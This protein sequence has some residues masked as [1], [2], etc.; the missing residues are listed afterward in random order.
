M[1]ADNV[2]FYS[3]PVSSGIVTNREFA[4]MVQNAFATRRGLMDKF[5]DPRKDIDAECGYPRSGE[6]T[7][8]YSASAQGYRELY[9][10]MPIARRVVELMPK[11]SWQTTPKVYE[12]NDPDDNTEFEKDW[13]NL[14][15]TLRGEKSWYKDEAGSPVWEYLKRVDILAGIGHFG[16][17]LLGIDDGKNLDQPLDGVVES[18]P[19]PSNPTQNKAK[20]PSTPVINS[21]LPSDVKDEEQKLLPP[22]KVEQTGTTDQQPGSGYDGMSVGGFA[23]QPQG[24]EAQYVGVQ[25]SPSQKPAETPSKQKRQLLFLRAF[26]ESLVQIVQYEADIRN[27]RFGKPVMYRITLN[28]PR[29]QT[30]GIGL[31]TA[32]VRVHW[33]RVIHV[34][35][36]LQSSEVMGTPR[37]EPVLNN[38]LD[39]KKIYGSDAEGYWKSCFGGLQFSTHP[40]LGGDVGV[41]LDQ[42]RDS[43][44]N[45]QQSL[46]RVLIGVGGQWSTIAPSIVDP[47]PHIEVG[48]T[49][50]CIYLS[51]PK[52]IF[53]GS[54]QGQ[55]AADQDSSSWYTKRVPD[56]WKTFNTPRIIIPFVDR[57]IQCGV[58]SEP[59]VDQSKQVDD[60]DEATSKDYPK[61]P[62]DEG[63]PTSEAAPDPSGQ[64]TTSKP[65]AFPT[66]N[67]LRNLKP[68]IYTRQKTYKVQVYNADTGKMEQKDKT[69]TS[70]LI[71]TDTG[72]SIEYPDPDALSAKDKAG[73]LLQ[74]TQAYGAYISSGME[75]MIP[76]LDYMTSFDDFDDEQA[77]SMLDSAAESHM[78]EETMT[79]APM[80]RGRP[81]AA[82]EGQEGFNKPPPDGMFPEGS[83]TEDEGDTSTAFGEDSGPT[84]E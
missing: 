33:S 68:G 69:S 48:L 18:I 55:L 5:F 27:P 57:L 22:R 38:I 74:K 46:Q 54:E 16:L 42:I 3:H 67:M 21:K 40:Q 62:G 37:M 63:A 51:C 23:S 11:E 82:E 81:G 66:A 17:L 70:V 58:L 13:D 32:T 76:P 35:D 79:M 59:N 44:E 25:L 15:R 50:I 8:L 36:N 10:R 84:E 60:V 43:A 52:R 28:D 77:Q 14:A 45:Y 49:A 47:T 9:D 34:A 41:N 6:T 53:M 19:D 1:P 7:G 4:E 39:L 72:Y 64:K 61:M 31:S 65:P 12:T 56:R 30:S 24:T 73:I 20:Y 29:E 2:H 26:D 71:K 83:G 78:A 80:D 75:A